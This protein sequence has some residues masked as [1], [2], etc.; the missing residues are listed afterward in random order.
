MAERPVVWISHRAGK[1]CAGCAAEVFTRDF[2][3]ITGETGIRCAK[4]AGL[5]D[6]VYLPVGDP[7]LIRR[8][9]AHSSRAVTVVKFSRARRRHERPGM[10]VEEMALQR[11]QAECAADAPGGKRPAP[12]AG[13]GRSAPSRSTSSASPSACSSASQAAHTPRPRPSRSAPAR[14]RV[15]G[16]AARRRV[17]PS[18]SSCSA[19]AGGRRKG[20]RGTRAWADV[21]DGSAARGGGTS[22]LKAVG[23]HFTD[24]RWVCLRLLTARYARRPLTAALDA[25]SPSLRR[26]GGE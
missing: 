12:G 7:T 9:V 25:P 11:A 17:S 14:N 24:Y 13:L 20:A 3:Q 22:I 1:R 26:N 19:V 18:R 4:C 6:L 16:W 10:L 5:A 15:G 21:P 23:R 2:V 8:A